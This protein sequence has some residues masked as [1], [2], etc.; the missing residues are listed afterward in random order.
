M[1]IRGQNK[2]IF[3]LSVMDTN[4]GLILFAS[5]DMDVNGYPWM[6][7]CRWCDIRL[8]SVGQI[9]YSCLHHIRAEIR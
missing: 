5:A 8:R 9:L 7:S 2:W 1:D 4:V 3:Q 6:Q